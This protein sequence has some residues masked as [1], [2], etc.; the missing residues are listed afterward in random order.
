[1]RR[2]G[3]WEQTVIQLVVSWCWFSLRC[4]L[5]QPFSLLSSVFISPLHSFPLHSFPLP[6]S[7]SSFFFDGFVFLPVGSLHLSTLPILVLFVCQFRSF[8]LRGYLIHLYVY[9]N[10]HLS[11]CVCVCACCCWDTVHFEFQDSVWSEN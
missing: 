11:V 1:M 4:Y 5:L 7:L 3:G 10:K 9:A 2:G 8:S 6:C